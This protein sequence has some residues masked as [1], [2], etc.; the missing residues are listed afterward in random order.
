MCYVQAPRVSIVLPQHP[1]YQHQYAVYSFQIQ[2]LP[3]TLWNCTELRFS[4]NI[5]WMIQTCFHTCLLSPQAIA[6]HR[7]ASWLWFPVPISEN[8]MT[9]TRHGSL[10]TSQ[11]YVFFCYVLIN[12]IY[13]ISSVIWYNYIH[14]HILYNCPIWLPHFETCLAHTEVLDWWKMAFRGTVSGSTSCDGRLMSASWGCITVYK[15]VIICKNPMLN[16]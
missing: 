16:P 9:V 7:V 2:P 8:P 6:D 3:R 13:T 14:L 12:Y 11:I 4:Q 15:W 1:S 5:S 10:S